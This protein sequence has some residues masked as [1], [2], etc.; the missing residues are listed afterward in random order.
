MY[1]LTVSVR[2]QCGLAGS[3][4]RVSWDWNQSGG[5]TVFLCGGFRR[6]SVS[7]VRIG[8]IQFYAIAGPRSPSP[9]W[10]SVAGISYLLE[11]ACISWLVPFFHLQSQ[12]HRSSPSHTLSLSD[13]LVCLLSPTRLSDVWELMRYT[14]L[15]WILEVNF[16]LLRSAN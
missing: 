16:P 10:L 6:D 15:S 7:Q 13:L 1:Y 5:R 3:M 12:Q 4:L 11:A 8:G 9:R 14:R 2:A